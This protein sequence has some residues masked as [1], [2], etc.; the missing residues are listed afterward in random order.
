MQP[1]M[2]HTTVAGVVD[3]ADVA[4]FPYSIAVLR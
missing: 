4:T 2:P 3:A 1:M